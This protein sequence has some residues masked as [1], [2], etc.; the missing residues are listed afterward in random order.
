[1]IFQTYQFYDLYINFGKKIIGIFKTG[2]VITIRPREECRRTFYFYLVE[3][4]ISLY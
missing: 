3:F 2:L 1:M 4:H